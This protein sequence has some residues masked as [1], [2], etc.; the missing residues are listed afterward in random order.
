VE[1]FTYNIYYY[2]VICICF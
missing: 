1:I 2:I